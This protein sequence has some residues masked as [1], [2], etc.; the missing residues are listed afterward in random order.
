MKE[1]NVPMK[2]VLEYVEEEKK[3][4]SHNLAENLHIPPET[5][6]MRLRR[7]WDK[8]YLDRKGEPIQGGGRK[9]V[10]SLTDIGESRLNGLEEE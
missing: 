3:V 9:Y 2:E 4:S 8:G 7:Y 1:A 10:Y 6:S 5:G